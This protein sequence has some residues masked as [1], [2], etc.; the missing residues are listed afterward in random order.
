MLYPS[1]SKPCISRTNVEKYAK[2][3]NGTLKLLKVDIKKAE[4]Y[5]LGYAQTLSDFERYMKDNYYY[6][7]ANDS[8]SNK[9]LGAYWWDQRC[10]K[11]EKKDIAFRFSNVCQDGVPSAPPIAAPPHVTDTSRLEYSYFRDGHNSSQQQAASPSFIRQYGFNESDKN[12]RSILKDE[13][14]ENVDDIKAYENSL[15]QQ[16]PL[17]VNNYFTWLERNKPT[18]YQKGGRMPNKFNKTIVSFR[19]KIHTKSRKRKFVRNKVQ[20]MKTRIK[21]FL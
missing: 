13:Y 5:N 8:K 11:A 19:N 6:Q 2:K 9:C 10:T 21:T 20:T 7:Y 1:V 15:K 16:P 12:V 4:Q 3:G 18:A 17:S 14:S